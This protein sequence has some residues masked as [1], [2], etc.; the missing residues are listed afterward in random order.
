MVTFLGNTDLL[1]LNETDLYKKRIC[2]HHFVK[3]N[4]TSSSQ[5]KLKKSAVP[6]MFTVNEKD[7]LHVTTPT[8]TYQKKQ[9]CQLSPCVVVTKRKLSTPTNSSLSKMNS[10]F[11]M[12]LSPEKTIHVLTPSISQKLQSS[13]STDNTPDI[14]PRTKTIIQKAIDFPSPIKPKQLFPV[15]TSSTNILNKLR[16]VIAHQKKLLMSKRVMISKL[17]K[18]LISLKLQNKHNKNVQFMNL[19]HF[20]SEDSKTLVGMQ[21]SHKQLSTKPWSQKEKQFALSLFYKSPSAYKF[22]RNS[23][24]IILPGLTT[25]KR[26][27]GGSKCGPGF[28][29][30]IFKQ[31]KTKADS[32]TEQEK[33]CTLVFDELKIKNFLEYSKYLDLVEGYEDLGPKGRTNK[34][35]GQAMVFVIRGLYSSWKMPISY[36]LPATSVKHLVLSELL[37]EAVTRL[38]NCGFIVKAL[39]CDQGANNVAAYKDLKITKDEPYFLVGDRKVLAMFDVPHL[40]KN[41]RNNLIK[42]NF[43]FEGKE[44]SFKDIKTTYEYDKNS[45][46]SRALLHI[47]DAHINPGPFQ[48][49][50]CKLA[51]QLFSNRVVT[52]MKTCIMTGQLK[53]QTAPQTVKM[54]KKL[55]DLMDCLNSN[56]LFNS[57]PSKCAL[58]DKCPQQLALLVKAKEWFKTL[59]IVSPNQKTIRPICFDGME[60]T[61]NAMIMLFEEQKKMGY[62]YLLTRRVNSDVI[63]NMFSVFRQRGGYNR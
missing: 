26:W 61:I 25:I 4:F 41:L 46:T 52:A 49:M 58:S 1:H 56:S 43:L 34:L 50:S 30:A 3:N 10:P 22:L 29:T 28:N 16:K 19:L 8:I 2:E 53:S 12:T 6:Q 11:K 35:A 7:T 54:I 13:F 42:K 23:K 5:Q 40:F 27:I 45:S 18:H 59:N 37:V 14:T 55:N 38:F 44:V 36:F 33:Y 15:S 48:L 21:V 17:K 47:T 24:K 39:V 32:M 63:E 62:H 9:L 57:N 20:P 31:L 51:M 60:W